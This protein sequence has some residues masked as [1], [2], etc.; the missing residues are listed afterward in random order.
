MQLRG[1]VIPEID[2]WEKTY[3]QGWMATVRWRWYVSTRGGKTK[4]QAVWAAFMECLRGRY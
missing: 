3:K 1:G 4:R 2:V